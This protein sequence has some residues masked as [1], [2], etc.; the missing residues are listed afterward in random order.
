MKRLLDRLDGPNVILLLVVVGA[1]L[2]VFF[3]GR[4]ML[5]SAPG[6]H[7]HAQHEVAANGTEAKAPAKSKAIG[8]CSMHPGIRLPMPGK[9]PICFM[10]LIPV[11]TINGGA[12]DQDRT[13]ALSA[14]ARKA[15]RVETRPVQRDRA[16]VSVRMAG[17]ITEDETR[18]AALTSRVDG[19]LD[20]LYVAFTGE[21]V[22]KGDPM[23][24]IWSPTLIKSQVELFETIKG[25]AP[26]PAV[27]RGAEE[28]LIQLGLTEK[29]IAEIKERAKADLYVT[30]RAPINGV[31]LK[32]N[33]VLGQFVKEGTEMFIIN[34]LS[35]VWIMLDA[36]ETDIPWIRYGQNATFSAAALP[37]KRFVGKVLFIDPVLDARNRTVRVR[38]EAENPDLALRPGMFVSGELKAEVDAEGR[39]IRREWAGKWVC[40]VHPRDEAASKPGTCPDSQMPL[41]P[42]SS[43]GYSDNPDPAL[44][45]LVPATA[46]L[47]T[48]KRAIVYVEVPDRDEPTYELREVVL[49]PKSEAGYVVYEGLRE[50]ER[51]VVAGAFKIDAAMQI[52]GKPSMMKPSAE[53][54][55]HTGDA[56]PESEFVDKVHA[57]REF[58]DRLTRLMTR[59][60]SLKDAL[61]KGQ[62][63]EARTFAEDLANVL[64][65][66]S[67]DSLGH[68][69]RRLWVK[70]SETLAEA[71]KGVAGGKD[72]QQARSAFETL[73]ESLA[74]TLMAFRHSSDGPIYVF[75][76]PMASNKKGAYWLDSHAEVRNPYFGEKPVNGQVMLRCG[77]L[78]ETI[79]PEKEDKT[80]SG[81]R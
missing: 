10:D 25:S 57:P 7:D 5:G 16:H 15:A 45:L 33:A 26:D 28:K 21:T 60:L 11:E 31:V 27:I 43:Y 65:E 20:K 41:R 39:V 72:L 34:D 9:C 58:L 67:A 37:G 23:V 29:Q 40:P 24:T 8:T 47:I 12:G 48:G 4:W 74:R 76:C 44:P 71:A 81:L 42:A 49:G 62:D 70:A 36:Y 3:A 55:P 1:G 64:G 30:L 68:E 18:T 59:Y 66:M 17:I 38:L 54:D 78:I 56:G 79:P 19:R 75:H 50:G 51:V 14:S 13:L 46:P 73:S 22:V 80:Q 6:S 32:K 35:R 69:A 2:V 52:L 61:V 63:G 77:E 53:H